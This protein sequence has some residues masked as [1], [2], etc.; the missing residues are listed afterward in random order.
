MKLVIAIYRC[1]Y[2]IE[3]EHD[4]FEEVLHGDLDLSSDPW[5]KISESAKDLVRKMLVR[6]PR[7]RL[8]AH[9]VLCK[10]ITLWPFNCPEAI[11]FTPFVS[12]F[13]L[14]IAQF[15]CVITR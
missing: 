2:C 1:T 11:T 5:P 14:S 13:W 8:T 15:K 9:E 7:K 12:T 10:S 4:I 3:T 6:D